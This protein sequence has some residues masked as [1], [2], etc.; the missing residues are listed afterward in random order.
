M[1]GPSELL[2][3]DPLVNPATAELIFVE[4]TT[5]VTGINAQLEPMTALEQI[6]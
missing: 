3:D 2:A 1:R 4:E 5:T 6:L